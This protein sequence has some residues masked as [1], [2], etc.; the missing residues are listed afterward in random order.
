MDDDRDSGLD[1][2]GNTDFGLDGVG[3]TARDDNSTAPDAASTRPG[4]WLEYS[5]R[6]IAEFPENSLS[7]ENLARLDRTL[8]RPAL[9]Y[10]RRQRSEERLILRLRA[11]HSLSREQQDTPQ[12]GPGQGGDRLVL[13]LRGARSQSC[14]QQ[15][16]PHDGPAQSSEQQDVASQGEPSQDEPSQ[17]NFATDAASDTSQDEYPLIDFRPDAGT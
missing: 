14:S 4:N 2:G 12:N 1:G 17:D 9:S 10:F 16:A 3:A 11:L 13:R 7:A 5:R 6:T 8:P 15:D